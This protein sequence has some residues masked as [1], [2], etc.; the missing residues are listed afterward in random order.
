[1]MIP[2]Y[3]AIYHHLLDNGNIFI[4]CYIFGIDLFHLGHAFY[5]V[6]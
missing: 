2:S 5:E 3:Y 6:G 4:S 1:M